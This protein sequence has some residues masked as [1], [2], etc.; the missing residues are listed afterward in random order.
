MSDYKQDISNAITTIIKPLL[1]PLMRQTLLC[2]VVGSVD[3]STHT[4]KVKP[5]TDDG[6]EFDARLIG[7]AR[8]S[9]DVLITPANGST[10]WVTRPPVAIGAA[11]ITKVD[12]YKAV[13]I[14]IGPFKLDLKAA[15]GVLVLNDG[16]NKGVPM[17]P[18]VVTQINKLEND[19]NQ[20][21]TI[22]STWVVVPSDG[23]AALKALLAP[24]YTQLTPTILNDIANPKIQQ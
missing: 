18:N 8:N 11:F 12:K 23:G 4:I 3:T 17:S 15:D 19:I 2:T 22:L 16:N 21:K 10:V 24:Y 5:I 9:Y 1:K 20:L 14:Q 7:S 6:P 13:N